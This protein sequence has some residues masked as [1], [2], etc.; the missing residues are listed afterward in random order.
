MSTLFAAYLSADLESRLRLRTAKVAVLGLG[1][2]GL[3]LAVAFARAGFTVRAIDVDERKIESLRAGRSYIGDIS[4]ESLAEVLN[5]GSEEQ[6]AGGLLP[7]TQ[8]KDLA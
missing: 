5:P 2:V 1:Y 7:T 3:P 4:N 8:Y 6:P